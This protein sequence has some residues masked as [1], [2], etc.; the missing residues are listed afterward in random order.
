MAFQVLKRPG[1][2]YWPTWTYFETFLSMMTQDHEVQDAFRTARLL[3]ILRTKIHFAA[4][5]AI[6]HAGISSLEIY[7]ASSTSKEK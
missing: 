3:R 2:V 1:A 5:I 7:P 6:V 4:C